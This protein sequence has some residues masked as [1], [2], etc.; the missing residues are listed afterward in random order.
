[1]ETSEA[2]S[3]SLGLGR[4][5]EVGV[6]PITPKEE[7]TLDTRP[8]LLSVLEAVDC[9]ENDYLVLFGVCLLRAI[10]ENEGE[11]L[12]LVEAKGDLLISVVNSIAV[13]WKKAKL[14]LACCLAACYY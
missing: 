4:T 10:Q 14:C 5:V 3:S 7:F 1:M 11:H 8:F 2:T 13:Q 12:L 9:S 6:G